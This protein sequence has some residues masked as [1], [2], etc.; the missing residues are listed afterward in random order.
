MGFSGGGGGG[1][2]NGIIVGTFG[3]SRRTPLMS[4]AHCHKNQAATAPSSRP[5]PHFNG[6]NGGLF[7]A[8]DGVIGICAVITQPWL[9]LPVTNPT[10]DSSSRR[11][12]SSTSM[13]FWYCTIASPRTIT[14]KSGFSAFSIR[15]RSSS[16]PRVTG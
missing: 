12:R 10:W 4:L 2:G 9:G 1:G 16:S 15:R 7:F 3:A 13:T 6:R 5:A 14:G 11:N 8:G